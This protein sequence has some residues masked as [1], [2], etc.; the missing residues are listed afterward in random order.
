MP[1]GQGVL[2]EDVGAGKRWGDLELV[3][4]NRPPYGHPA[5]SGAGPPT[6]G[7]RGTYRAISNC[8][9]HFFFSS[10]VLKKSS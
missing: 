1:I 9:S 8:S 2:G 7:C 3:G 5:P 6:P 10:R 4:V